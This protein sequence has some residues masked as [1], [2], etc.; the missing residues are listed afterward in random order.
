[1]KGIEA[2]ILTLSGGAIE[3]AILISRGEMALMS[4]KILEYS[5]CV[6]DTIE[7]REPS[8]IVIRNPSGDIDET[9]SFPLE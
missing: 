3:P 8:A 9:P 1:V 6:R 5:Q 7:N 2:G 4:S